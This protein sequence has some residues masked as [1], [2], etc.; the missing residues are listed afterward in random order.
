[1]TR[2]TF[3]SWLESQTSAEMI[4]EPL[5][6]P[7]VGG[8]MMVVTL[9]LAM[10]PFSARVFVKFTPRILFIA[11]IAVAPLA[12]SRTAVRPLSMLLL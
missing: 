2:I 11:F 12:L 3:A 9:S 8:S 1:M 7:L 4:Y 10:T 5:R 6:G